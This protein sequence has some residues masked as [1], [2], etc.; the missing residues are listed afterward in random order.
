MKQR[1]VVFICDD[2][3]DTGFGEYV[4]HLVEVTNGFTPYDA[5]NSV[6]LTGVHI[7]EEPGEH[8]D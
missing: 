2:D 4:D 8:H 3:E 7:I 6:T 1:V 5:N